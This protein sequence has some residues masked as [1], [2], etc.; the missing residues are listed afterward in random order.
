MIIDVNGFK[1]CVVK[2]SLGASVQA[3]GVSVPVSSLQY[4][5]LCYKD[6]NEYDFVVATLAKYLVDELSERVYNSSCYRSTYCS[7]L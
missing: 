3:A 4:D 7:T 2:D 1:M 6:S 5:I